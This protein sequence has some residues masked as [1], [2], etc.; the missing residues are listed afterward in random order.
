MRY[1]IEWLL[2]KVNNV[3]ENIIRKKSLQYNILPR[4][5]IFVGYQKSSGG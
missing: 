4:I 2:A 3:A 1:R 5:A